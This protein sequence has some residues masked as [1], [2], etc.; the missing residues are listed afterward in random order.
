M[1]KKLQ[2]E[3]SELA[4]ELS[5]EGAEFNV[6]KVKQAIRLIYEKLT[7]L[8]YL[9][10][11]L[12]GDD[13]SFDSKSFREKN[14]FVEPEPVPQP[15]HNEE[16]VEPVMEK[17][18]DIVAQMPEEADQVDE[19]L[20]EVLPEKKYLKNDLE[21]FASSYQETPVFER[22][23]PE[24]VKTVKPPTAIKP[25]TLPNDT[26]ET[27]RPKSLNE[28]AK[29][30]LNIGLNDRHAFIK[31]LFNDSTDDYTR[32]L[33][34]INSMQSF[35]EADTFIKGKVKPDYNYWL[36]KDKYA[37]RFMALVEQSFN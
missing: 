15:D 13:Q 14:W 31:H 37:K 21:E 28:V 4:L 12:E 8:E 11:Q 32:V 22:K 17:I 30:G 26:D 6:R 24:T 35:E 34:Q 36:H 7:V 5:G 2:K 3:I 16:L 19:L 23:E 20:K 29:S 9:E 25:E 27:N 1:K 33:S 18:K 10:G